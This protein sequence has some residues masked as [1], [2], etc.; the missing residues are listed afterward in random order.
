[1]QQKLTLVPAM[2]K[3]PELLPRTDNDRIIY[4]YDALVSRRSTKT[5]SSPSTATAMLFSALLIILASVLQPCGAQS[6]PV[7]DL[8]YAR[9]RGTL[10]PA[11]SNNTQF[12][13][14]RFAAPPTGSLR[15]QAPRTPGFVTGIQNATAEP[16]R[17]LQGGTGAAPSNSFPANKRD[18]LAVPNSEDCLFLNV[19]IPGQLDSRSSGKNLPVV[20]WIHGGGYVAGSANGFSGPDAYDGNDLVRESGD[21][22]IAVVIQYRLGLFGFLAGEEVKVN[23][24]LNAGLLDQQFALQWVQE[25]IAKFGGDPGRVTIW[26][27]SAGAGSVLQQV[28]A[29]DGKTFPPLFRAAITSSSFLPSQYAFNDVVPEFLYNSV[30]SRTNCTSAANS[31]ACL[32]NADVNVLEQININ[33][34]GSGFFGTFVFVPVV[35]GDFIKQRPALALLEGK[36]NG[37]ALM[38]VTNA[39]EGAIFVDS[40]TAGTV[41]VPEYLMQLFPSLSAQ[42]RDVAVAKY[43]GLGAP[44]DQVTAIMGDHICLPYIL[45]ASR[46]Q[47]KGIQ[48]KLKVQQRSEDVD[49][50]FN[51]GQF[52][53]PPATHG[54]DVS[55]YFPSMNANGVPSFSNADF[56]KAFA[57]SFLA[58]AMSLDPNQTFEPTITPDWKPFSFQQGHQVE[59]RFNRT[60][61]GDPAVSPFTTPED[62]LDRC[63][64][65][66]SV[67][68]EI[69]Q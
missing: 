28:I 45:P 46:F 11:G 66:E 29:N 52:A 49:I 27:E 1:M 19:Y 63:S 36:V 40:T 25:H 65:W 10:D 58:F 12:L 53:I 69:G 7:I 61:S 34:C 67:G 38:S 8:G 23:G 17:C 32:R 26:G 55:F 18:S 14:I 24:R 48:G 3:N 13:G 37:E 50:K 57:E 22:I 51:Q 16:P 21:G 54:M 62:L 39:D 15:W 9:Y 35:D 56:D 44:I 2:M 5:S 42:H 30:V 60:E 47:R 43:S 64:F 6:T 20:V 68:P 41:Q 33:L 59:M 4:C 31:L